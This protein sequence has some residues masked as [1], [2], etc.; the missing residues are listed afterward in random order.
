M[1]CEVQYLHHE[2]F[3]SSDNLLIHRTDG[4]PTSATVVEV[5]QVRLAEELRTNWVLASQHQFRG[6]VATFAAAIC[7]FGSGP[8][9]RSRPH[10]QL[11]PDAG[12]ETVWK[13]RLAARQGVPEI[14]AV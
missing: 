12:P 3:H 2:F 8:V 1:E 5:G 11:T 10:A 13:Q 7:C 14:L 9:D 4:I 6:P